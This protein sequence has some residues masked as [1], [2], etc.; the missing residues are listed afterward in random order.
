MIL[1][2]LHPDHLGGAALFPNAHF[3]VTQEVY[4]VYQKPKFKDLI[5]K[6]FLPAD[7]KDR[8][9]C[10]KADQRHPAFPYR[11]TTDLFSD[12]SILV[13]SIDGHARGQGCLYLD[14][15]KLFIGADLSWGV[16]LLPFTRQMRLIPSLVQDDKKAYLKGADLLE[17]LLQDGIQ[18]VVSHDPQERIE[19]ILNE[20]NSLSKNLY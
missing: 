2:H 16:D 14:E 12:G 6:E 7:F 1:S 9:T 4:E 18:V 20:K 15:L 11:P 5:F 17:T 13:S 8:V 19:R 10:L 3:L